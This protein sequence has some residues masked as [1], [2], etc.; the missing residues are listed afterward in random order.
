LLPW[1][2]PDL[3]VSKLSVADNGSLEAAIVTIAGLEGDWHKEP[4][5]GQYWPVQFFARIAFPPG[6]PVGDTQRVWKRS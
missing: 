1:S 4:D 6:N 5:T 2:Y 3:D